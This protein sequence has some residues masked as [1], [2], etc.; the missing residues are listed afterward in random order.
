MD[1]VLVLVALLIVFILVVG[2]AAVGGSCGWGRVRTLVLLRRSAGGPVPPRNKAIVVLTRG[3][4]DKAQYKQL[5]AR[6]T[7]LEKYANSDIDYIIFHE[8]NIDQDH[9]HYISNFTPKLK[10]TFV[11]VSK[12][13]RTATMEFYQPTASFNMGYR[14][15]CSF[16]FVE[17]WKYVTSYSYI[18]RIDEDCLYYSDPTQVLTMLEGSNKVAA[19]GEFSN[20]HE[21]VTKGLNQFTLDFLHQKG[22]RPPPAQPSGPYT[23]VIGLNLTLL[24]KNVMLMEYIKAVKLSNNIYIYRWGDLPLWGE[25]LRYMYADK[26]YAVDP[27]IHYFHGS[28]KKQVGIKRA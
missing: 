4:K 18:L 8:G 7:H 20:D 5:I 13:F 21:S 2:T 22:I 12:D 19:F 28:H 27:T 26:D 1:S 16:W 9:Q 10:I 11:D 15:M 17:F 24:R 3:Y 14:N 25:V 23:N 6:N